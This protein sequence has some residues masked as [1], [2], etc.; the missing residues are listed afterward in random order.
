M[1][2]ETEPTIDDQIAALK[3][4]RR[5]QREIEHQKKVLAPQLVRKRDRLDAAHKRIGVELTEVRAALAAVDAGKL[6]DYC[7]RKPR[8]RKPKPE[9]S[10][11]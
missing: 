4:K 10:Q 6:T 5:E 8:R 1:T 9:K 2:T 7:V 11:V 3:Q